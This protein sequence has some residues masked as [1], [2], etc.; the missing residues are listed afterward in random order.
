MSVNFR[1]C[2]SGSRKF[3]RLEIPAFKSGIL[4]GIL[5]RNLNLVGNVLTEL[6]DYVC[7][8]VYLVT[9]LS[10]SGDYLVVDFGQNTKKNNTD[11]PLDCVQD[12]VLTIWNY[13]KENQCNLTRLEAAGVASELVLS[14]LI[15]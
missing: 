1:E 7:V 15:E 6:L 13:T 5:Q 2:G 12:L 4:N 8:R 3:Y 10:L 9:C 11:V 14:E